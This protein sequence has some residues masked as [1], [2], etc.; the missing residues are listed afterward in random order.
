MVDHRRKTLVSKPGC[1]VEE[2][3]CG[4]FHVSVGAVT[5]RLPRTQLQGLLEA[6]AD[7]LAPEIETESG[8]PPVH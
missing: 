2:C 6:L 1:R 5:V 3:T 4:V 8:D 7:A